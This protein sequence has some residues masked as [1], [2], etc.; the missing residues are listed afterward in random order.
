MEKKSKSESGENNF[1][2]TA[3][4]RAADSN[5][6]S[7]SS[8]KIWMIATLVLAVGLVIILGALYSGYSLPGLSGATG[9][10][11]KGDEAGGKLVEFLNT[12]T[13]GGVTYISS[14]DL[15][16]NLYQVTVAYQGQNV[17]V[18][19]TKDGKYFVQGAIPLEAGAEDPTQQT[20]TTPE[21]PQEIAKSDKP[22]VEL[23]VMTHCPYGTQAEKGFIPVVNTL[24]KNADVKV[25][26]VHYFMHGDKEEQ[27][28]YNQLCIREE[29]SDKYMTYLSCF[30]EAGDTAGCLTKANI[31]KTKLNTCLSNSA[32]KAKE[33]YKKDSELSQKYGVEGS[34]TLVING[35]IANSGR[36]SASLL[37]TACSGF[38]T[39]P[40]G[41]SQKLSTASPAPGFGT[42]D[43]PAGSATDAQC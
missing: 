14:E 10:F 15:G 11:V 42:A 36:D 12:R 38:N 5:D 2:E 20:P 7:K 4:E 40:S 43:A 21:T 33:Y 41:C 18:F 13:G 24:S 37:K 30:L 31:D 34:P 3:E 29:Q 27:E 1:Q 16:G 35:V 17:P 28:T 19:I 32:A 25:R 22:A 39:E 26:F 23:F 9:N 8:G 6:S